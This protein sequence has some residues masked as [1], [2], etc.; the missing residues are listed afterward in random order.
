MTRNWHRGALALVVAGLAT[1]IF[2]AGDEGG[3]SEPPGPSIA[4]Q[5]MFT[6]WTDDACAFRGTAHLSATRTPQLYDCE[7][8]AHQVC[9]SV[10]WRVRQ[11][12]TA[13]RVGDQLII[14]SRIEEF[15]EG[16]PTEAYW[17]DNFILSIHSDNRMT[18]SLL[19]HGSHASEFTRTEGGT[20]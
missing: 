14:N 5:W 8:T 10:T 12:C 17:P 2:A 20:S 19:S 18:G 11:S 9:P 13:R 15:L 3:Q 16:E 6:S 7:L 4:G 1:P